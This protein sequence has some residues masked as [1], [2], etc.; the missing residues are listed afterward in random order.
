MKHCASAYHATN[1]DGTDR[2]WYC[3]FPGGL[4]AVTMADCKACPFMTPYLEPRRN[5]KIRDYV[6]AAA[7]LRQEY[8]D[9][10]GEPP[11]LLLGDLP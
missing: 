6:D 1:E 11:P 9:R 5:P 10:W 3:S 4:I 7:A 8:V 2:G